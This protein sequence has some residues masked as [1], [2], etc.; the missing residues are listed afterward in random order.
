M[1]SEESETIYD[2]IAKLEDEVA[3][4]R[5]EIDFLKRALRNELARHEVKMA[6]KGTEVSSLID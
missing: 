2:R 6:K 3:A 1:S 5:S 4:L